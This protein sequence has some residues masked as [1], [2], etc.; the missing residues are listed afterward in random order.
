[1]LETINAEMGRRKMRPGEVWPAADMTRHRWYYI[2]RNPD[3]LTVVELGKLAHVLG[4]EPSVLVE[5]AAAA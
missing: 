3:A 1:M 4:L 2:Q 5:Q